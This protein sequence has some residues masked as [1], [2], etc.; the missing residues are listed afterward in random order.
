M[1]LSFLI[2]AGCCVIKICSRSFKR[3]AVR[4]AFIDISKTLAQRNHQVTVVVDNS[5][6]GLALI[7]PVAEIPQIVERLQSLWRS[8]FL[9]SSAIVSL[10][11]VASLEVFNSQTDLPLTFPMSQQLFIYC[12]NV[13]YDNVATIRAAKE[14][15][16]IIQY[17]YFLVEEK[18][19]IRLLAFVWY[20]PGKCNVA[21]LVEVNRFDKSTGRWQHGSFKIDKN[22]DFHGCR[23]N[24]MFNAGLPHFN[25]DKIDDKNKAITKCLRVCERL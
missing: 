10:R 13:A 23:I 19:V 6:N 24:F 12:E 22:S 3:H 1:F 5:Q 20:T 18:N 17:E 21:Q 7:A 2:F 4:E 11:S 15:I 9:E 16:P 8:L 14:V 25:A